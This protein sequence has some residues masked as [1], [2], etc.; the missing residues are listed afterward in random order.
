MTVSWFAG[1]DRIADSVMSHGSRV[2]HVGGQ[3]HTPCGQ[4]RREFRPNA[5]RHVSSLYSPVRVHSRPVEAEDL[6]HG[7]DVALDPD[8]LLQDRK[9]VVYGRGCQYV[10]SPVVAVSLKKKTYKTK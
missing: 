4:P 9:S 5:G 10:S 6:L 2:E 8:D 7:D 1:S 3:V